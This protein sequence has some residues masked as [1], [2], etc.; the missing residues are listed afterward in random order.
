[1]RGD[2]A[3]RL[4]LLVRPAGVVGLVAAVAGVTAFAAAYLPWYEVAA[5]VEMLGAA[6]SR[7]VAGLAGWQAH[8]WGWAVLALALA[9]V[10]LGVAIVLDRPPAFVVK[11][12]LL[13]AL[14]LAV[15]FAVALLRVPPVARFDIA[16]SRVRE[17]AELSGRLPA[18]VDLTFDVRPGVGLWMT[19]GAAALLLATALASR[20]LT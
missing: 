7:A 3:L 5:R 6:Q 12:Q 16:G 9:G 17:L 15:A 13:V 1:M 11:G 2:T 8:P 10:A 20:D 19:L 18:D 14:G 4:R